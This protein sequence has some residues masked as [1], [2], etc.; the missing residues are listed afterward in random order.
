MEIKKKKK[1]KGTC[2]QIERERE[3]GL[4]FRSV[5][6]IWLVVQLTLLK[7]KKK[8]NF[9]QQRACYWYYICYVKREVT[10]GRVITIR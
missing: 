3:G 6:P 10:Y 4:T 7:K 9:K 2:L 5:S 8:K 1:K